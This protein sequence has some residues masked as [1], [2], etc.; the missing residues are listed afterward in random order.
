MKVRIYNGSIRVR[1]GQSEV[2]DLVSKGAL[3]ERLEFSSQT[4]LRYRIVTGGGGAGVTARFDGSRLEIAVSCDVL[5]D[6]AE[7]DEVSIHAEQDNG[8]GGLRILLEKD[9]ACV[10]RE[11]SAED[12]D[13]F[14]RPEDR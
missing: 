8:A 11:G 9:F 14:P 3:E 5:K 6:W 10:H 7:G 13:T 2:A 12:A 4:A 1:L